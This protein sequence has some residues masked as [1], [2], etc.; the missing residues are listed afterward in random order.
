M[1]KSESKFRQLLLQKCPHAYIKKI[2]DFKQTGSTLMRGLPDYL[3]ICNGEYFWFEVKY[4]KSLKTFN[5]NEIN[6]Y[7]WIEFAKLLK[8][9]V[10]VNITIY[11]SNYELFIIPFNSLYDMKLSNIKKI[12]IK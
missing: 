5:F 8:N 12:K 2:P 10:N 4:I 9:G 1:N 3:V 6:D 7:Q 11:N